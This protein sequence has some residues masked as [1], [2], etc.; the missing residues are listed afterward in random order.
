MPLR[1]ML[2]AA[3]VQGILSGRSPMAK[4]Y[5][6]QEIAHLAVEI[7]DMTMIE[8]QKPPVVHTMVPIETLVDSPP[9]PVL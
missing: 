5:T 1:A 7:A 8:L 3:A 2:T 9:E 6:T 4:P